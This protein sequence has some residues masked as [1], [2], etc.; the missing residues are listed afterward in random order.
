M[1]IFYEV[2]THYTNERIREREHEDLVLIARESDYVPEPL[3]HQVAEGLRWLAKRLDADYE[4]AEKRL[5]LHY[6]HH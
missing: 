6:N 4:A 2:A 3:L 5:I 1:D